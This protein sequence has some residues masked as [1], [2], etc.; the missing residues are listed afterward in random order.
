VYMMCLAR[1]FG[2]ASLLALLA[3]F[4]VGGVHLCAMAVIITI[5]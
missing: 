5:C 3:L 4:G 2:D 1:I